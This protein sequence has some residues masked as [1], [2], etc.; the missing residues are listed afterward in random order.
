MTAHSTTSTAASGQTL[1]RATGLSKRFRIYRKPS[2]R[3]LEWLSGRRLKLHSEFWALRGLD[4][5]VHRGECLGIIGRNGSGKST[6]LKLL[7]GTLTPTS[8]EFEI[9]GRLLSIIELGT[10]F[11]PEL[12]GRE[13]IRVTAGLLGFDEEYVRSRFD[14]MLE[15]ADIGEFLERPIKLYSSGMLARVAFAMYAFL[16]PEVLVVDEVLSV[17]DA[18][19]Q[20][21]CY[22]RME[23]MI[24]SQ[25]RAVI[26]VTH[27]LGAVTK[28]CTRA[29]WLDAGQVRMTGPSADVVEAYLKHTL[30]AVIQ[31]G[32]EA[33]ESVVAEPGTDATLPDGPATAVLSA[34]MSAAGLLP[35]SEAAVLYP[36]RGVQMAGV[37]I[38]DERG[39]RTPTV[40]VGRPFSICYAVRFAQEQDNPVFGVR[41]ATIR[42][43]LLIGTNTRMC[44]M[45]TRRYQAGETEVI[46][47]PVRGGLNAGTYFISVGV[48]RAENTQ[49]FLLREVD[50]Y[51]F[52]VVGNTH[53]GG[54]LHLTDK[55]QLGHQ[56]HGQVG[57]SV[58][59]EAVESKGA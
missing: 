8:G 23:Q 21:K 18:A 34:A 19:F 25:Q 14:Q 9:Q 46:R 35:R 27:D 54:L 1:I 47:W 11:N 6:L 10:G 20:R 42:G 15:F 16:E 53:S 50:G 36:A 41:V 17:G 38:E 51:Q 28:L 32:E 7:T 31:E 39:Q 13:N 59:R 43:D 26:L 5:Q 33:T 37:W 22:R 52:E 12:S 56:D 57:T 44:D 55:P 45:Q 49:Q 4:L 40:P 29:I 58:D 48:S 3:L 30:G 24:Q 2:Y